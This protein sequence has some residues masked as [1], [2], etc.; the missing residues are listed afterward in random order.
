KWLECVSAA[1][2]LPTGAS[3]E[4]EGSRR[5]G[6]EALNEFISAALE[7]GQVISADVEKTV[8]YWVAEIDKKLS[9]QLNAIMHSPQFQRLEGTWRGLHYLISN[10]ETG[11]RLK[12]RVLNATK[13]EIS[14]DL[15]NAVE[16]DM[17][18]TFKK[19]YEDEYG[20]LGGHPYG[21]LI[22]DYDYDVA[23]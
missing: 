5:N 1:A 9:D 3:A 10:S 4:E 17:S 20:I 8:N 14:K 19:V 13:T 21:I 11:E 6:L 18:Q 2:K 7:P 22:G 23:R 12:I 15:E 16:F